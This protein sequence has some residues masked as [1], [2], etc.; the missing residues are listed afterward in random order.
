MT[1]RPVR[2]STLR[3]SMRFAGAGAAGLVTVLA[4]APAAGA[5]APAGT[6]TA[7]PKNAAPKNAAP[8]NAAG[9]TSSDATGTATPAAEP[10]TPDYGMQKYRVGVG[11]DKDADVPAGTTTVGTQLTVTE[12]GPNAPETDNPFTCTTDASTVQP[13]STES[14][15]LAV[16]QQT[17]LA[18]R[19]KAA[20]RALRAR[21][22]AV[23]DSDEY[24]TAG[25]GDTITVVQKTVEPNLVID[26]TTRT[27]EPCEENGS[28]VVLPTCF[29]DDGNIKS[30]TVLFDDTGFPPVAKDDSASV[31]TGD[32]VDIAVLANDDTKGAK[33]STLSVTTKPRHGTAEVDNQEVD[34]TPKPGFVGTDTFEYTLKTANGSSTA[35]VTVKVNAPPPTANNDSARTTMDTPA[36]IDVLKNDDSNGGG[37]LT[38]KSV[39]KPAHGS[40]R[41]VNGRVLYTPAAGYV[42]GDHFSY[43]AGTDFGTDRATVTVTVSAAPTQPTSASSTSTPTTPLANTGT[44]SGPLLEVGAGLV[45]VGGVASVAGRRRRRGRH[46]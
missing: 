39:G 8:K 35:Q 1:A 2:R 32:S 3:S 26:P 6:S 31:Q 40:T 9:G 15:C 23:S 13:G 30:T 19:H 11:I 41:I 28:I 5:H 16:P 12:T 25:P 27:V 36:T 46:A 34:Y 18:V 29:A 4:A 38:L 33:S 44:P 45:V 20:A 37:P 43:T 14:Y 17:A 21:P 22:H 24:W 10:V 7:A 42:G